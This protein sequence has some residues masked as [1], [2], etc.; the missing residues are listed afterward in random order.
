M[1]RCIQIARGEWMTI[2]SDDDLLDQDYLS[3]MFEVLDR[4]PTSDGIVCR[5]RILDEREPLP[6]QID[7]RSLAW[8]AA[9]RALLESGF[10]GRT[11]RV[12]EP[13]KLFWGAVLG[14]PAG[15]MFKTQLVRKIGGYYPEE[16]PSSDI[17]L[18]SRFAALHELR[19]HRAVKATMR[20][21]ENE[22]A[23]PS[24]VRQGL[25]M[26]HK[27]YSSFVG[28][29]VPG[30]WGRIL[31]LVMARHRTEY[32]EFWRVDVPNAELEELLGIRL[33]KD[34][35]FLLRSIRLLLRGF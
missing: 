8:R 14:N 34:R 5:K 32:R 4:H 11:S 26:G 21:S 10:L 20:V 17:W 18:L 9:K 29:E 35:P 31:P 15:F 23:K 12:I 3:T 30:W 13:G 25:K 19:E 28:R 33:P 2:L 1:N 24:T 22:T 6:G 7:D 16:F 27:L